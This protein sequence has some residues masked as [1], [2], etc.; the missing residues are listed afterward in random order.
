MNELIGKKFRYKSKHGLSNWIGQ[1]KEWFI[2][3]TI[4]GDVNN[5]EELEIKPVIKI[6]SNSNSIYLLD[7][8][9]IV[10]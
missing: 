5:C 1:I 4:I 8:I 7:E 2:L 6:I 9:K 10:F 3:W